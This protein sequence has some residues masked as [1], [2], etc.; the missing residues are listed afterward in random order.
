MEIKTLDLNNSRLVQEVLAIHCVYPL[1][2]HQPDEQPWACVPQNL[3]RLES[4]TAKVIYYVQDHGRVVAVYWLEVLTR[5]SGTI[6]SLWV[7]P[8]YRRKGIAKSLIR[9]G[10]QWFCNQRVYLIEAEIAAHYPAMQSLARTMGYNLNE[11]RMSKDL[12]ECH[13]A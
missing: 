9:Q 4:S 11:Q 8:A 10:E 12:D 1:E 13:S 7:D 3:V 2:S 6:V 5:R